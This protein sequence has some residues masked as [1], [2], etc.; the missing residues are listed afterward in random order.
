VTRDGFIRKIATVV[1]GV[2]EQRNSILISLDA[3]PTLYGHVYDPN[4]VPISN[5]LLEAIKV[6]YGPRGDRSV[7]TV[8]SAL[9]DDR[10]EYHLYWLDPGD[11]YIRAS[12]LPQKQSD[13]TT[14]NSTTESSVPIYAPTYFPGFRDPKDATM[15]HLQLASNLNAFN[16]KLQTTTAVELWGHI[17]SIEDPSVGVGAEI[18]ATPAGAVASSRKYEGWST[19]PP[20]STK[21][22]GEF[23]LNGMASGTYIISAQYLSVGQMLTVHRKVTLKGPEHSL[24]LAVS[25]GSTVSGQIATDSGGAIELRGARLV[26]DSIDPDLPSPPMASVGPNGQFAVM[27]VEPGD[28]AI[29]VLDLPGDA[30]LKSAVSGKADILAKSL[31]VDFASPE[32][33]RVVLGVDGSR[34]DGVVEDNAKHPFAEAQVVLVPDASRRNSPDQFRITTSDVDGHFTLRGIP[35]GE[36]KL[37]A[38]QN[39]EANAYMNPIY[40]ENFERF[41]VSMTVP[42]VVSGNTSVRL[43]PM[44]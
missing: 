18:I 6:N 26:L 34:L 14:G 44:D 5:A 16:F 13:G 30:Y 32:S 43:I 35:P 29:R 17:S 21:D 33:I 10:G 23:K 39:V 4:N 2:G 12:L 42:S 7:V 8:V 19:G 11:Y 40:M 36:Y 27:R 25:P 22:L 9:S 15:I 31:R 38:W 41:G 28:Y 3:A 1:I 20:A 24:V 37:F